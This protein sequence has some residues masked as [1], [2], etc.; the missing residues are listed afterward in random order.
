[1]PKLV[2]IK[3][4]DSGPN[5]NYRIGSV[6]EVDPERAERLI[7]RG[8]AEVFDGVET[9]MLNYPKETTSRRKARK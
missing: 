2:R 6:I 3:M 1:M 4:L 7:S 5:L 9:S 8:H